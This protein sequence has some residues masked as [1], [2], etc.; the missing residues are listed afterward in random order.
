MRVAEK[1]DWKGLNMLCRVVFLI[2]EV[3]EGEVGINLYAGLPYI[4]VNTVLCFSV[5]FNFKQQN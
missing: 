1:L 3:C 4:Q 2:T 5:I